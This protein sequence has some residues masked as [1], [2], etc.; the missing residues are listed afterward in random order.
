MNG[1]LQE[2]SPV[3]E[4]DAVTADLI[5]NKDNQMRFSF[6]A[7]KPFNQ[8]SIWTAGV[9]SLN[10]SKYRIYYAFEEPATSTCLN[11]F[12]SAACLTMLSATQHGASINYGRTGF[13]GVA[14]VG[15]TMRNLCNVIDGDMTTSAYIGKVAGVAA[16]T[17][18]SIKT[19]RV[20]EHG[21]QPA[22]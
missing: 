10:I 5:G 12:S 19:N 8:V 13:G 16:N 17:S 3:D 15:A 6:V 21:Y 2:S 4:N 1:E 14:N 18:L 9:L 7:T 11:Q 20:F 22:L